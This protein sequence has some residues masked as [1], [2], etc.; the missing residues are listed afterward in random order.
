MGTKNKPLSSQDKQKDS[1]SSKS[2]KDKGDASKSPKAEIT[3]MLTEEQA[4]RFLKSAK[5]I[6]A[7]ELARQTGVKISAAN[8]FL[9]EAIVK[10]RVKRAGGH[11]GH[12]IY[13]P[14][15]A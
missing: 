13:Q 8:A 11:S 2:K 9:K 12:I 10:G 4:S 1:R 5:I 7:Q 3:V 15:A 14:V 6:T